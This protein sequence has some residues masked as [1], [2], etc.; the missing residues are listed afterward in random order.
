MFRKTLSA[1]TLAALLGANTAPAVAADFFG[2]PDMR[3][4]PYAA[5]AQARSTIAGVYLRV[6]FQSGIKHPRKEVRLGFGLSSKA[7]G[8]YHAPGHF[9][10]AGTTGLIDLSLGLSGQ[11]PLV[12]GLQLYGKTVNQLKARQADKNGAR[13]KRR[14]SKKLRNRSPGAAKLIGI[15]YLILAASNCRNGSTSAKC[16]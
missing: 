8:K 4:G 1:L 3:Y 5:H 12:D 9:A 7:S 10:A 13:K 14:T 11:Q 16:S 15:S 6:P 2:M